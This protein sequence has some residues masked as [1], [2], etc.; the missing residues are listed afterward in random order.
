MFRDYQERC[1]RK[2]VRLGRPYLYKPL[3]PPWILNFPTKEHWRSVSHLKDITRGLEYLLVHYKEWDIT[4]LAVPPLGCDHGQLEW[5]VAG[6]I[7]YRYLSCLDISV[8]LYVPHNIPH[9][10]LPPGL[11]H[12]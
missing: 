4:S 5:R 2:E 11:D 7:L 12:V 10:K 3:F 6:P 8:E 9:K 1:A